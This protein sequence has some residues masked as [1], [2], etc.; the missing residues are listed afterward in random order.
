[1]AAVPPL[2]AADSRNAEGATPPQY[3]LTL[4]VGCSLAYEVTGTA[5]VLLNVQ[6]M[7]DRNHAVVFEA[8]SL[9]NNLP[10][11]AFADTHGNRVLRVKLSPGTNCIRHDAIV[12]ATSR[13]VHTEASYSVA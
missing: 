7:P 9:G 6:P 5:S 12:A 3:D 11:E 2:G 8:L 1:M 4:R 10:A 13:P